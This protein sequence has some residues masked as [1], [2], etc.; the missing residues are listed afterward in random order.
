MKALADKILELKKEKNACIL[1]HNYQIGEIQ[2]IADFTGDSLGLS[3]QAAKTDADIIVFCG[4][5]FMAETAAILSPDKTVLMPEIEAGCPM[6]DMVTPEDIRNLRQQHPDAVVVSYVN[7]S[8]AVK[9]E[10]DICCTSANSVK[11]VESISRDKDVIFVPDKYLGSYTAKMTQRDLILWN[12]YCPPHVKILPSDIIRQKKLYPEA[13]V[14]V[15]PECSPEVLALAD[16]VCSTGGMGKYAEE[17]DATTFIVGTEPEM[18]FRLSQDNPS[19]T[20][21]PV[22]Q[23]ALCPNMKKTTLEKV[24]WSLEELKYVV[25]VPE[26]IRNRAYHAVERMINLG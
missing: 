24:L 4:V 5:R 13:K 25:E 8:A 2:L 3:R 18:C 20:F 9:A 26:T 15:H 14:M 23:N 1:V 12:G 16:A 10:S 19:K 7:S 17:V 22:T 6:A 11:V 21:Y